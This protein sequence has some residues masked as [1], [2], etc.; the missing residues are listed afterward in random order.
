MSPIPLKIGIIGGGAISELHLNS[1]QNN[2]AAELYAICDL[3]ESRAK[4]KA[5]QYNIP[6]LC[7]DYN[8]M[9]QLP[10]LEAVVICTWNNTHADIIMAALD[11]GKHVFVE[12]PLC[13]T[14]SDALAIQRKTIETGKTLQVGF[15]RRF[16][17]NVQ[18]LKTFI[19]HGDLGRIYYA[20]ASALRRLGNPGG[21]FADRE[22]SGG[23]PLIDVGIHVLDLSWYLMGC[24][25]PIAVSANTYNKLGNR[26]NIKN[27]AF[28]KTADYN[29]NF[30]N[31]EDLAN[32]MIRFENGASLYLDTSY[33]L[34]AKRNETSVVLYGE[35][36]GTEVLPET[37]LIIEKYNTILNARPQT[38]QDGLNVD[39]AFQEQTDHFVECC[40]ENKA[41]RTT[42]EHGVEIMR[43]IDAIYESSRTRKEIKLSKGRG[44]ES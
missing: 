25:R 24:P 12:K 39:A 17:P 34:H 23:G 30:N 2:S 18:M 16:D 6:H 1:Y 20:K 31:V 41:P 32:A 8:V 3:N 29:P 15:I 26:S 28:Y 4:Q 27:L 35:R 43:M 37:W 33:T 38:D 36:G 7:T 21:W 10:D 9:L 44:M 40:L 19:D 42:V 13:T 11:A 5:A 22:K 14:I